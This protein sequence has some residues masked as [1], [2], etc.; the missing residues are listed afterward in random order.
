MI[1]GQRQPPK[2][3]GWFSP[4]TSEAISLMFIVPVTGKISRRNLPVVTIGLILF[5]C[6]VFFIFQSNQANQYREAEGYYFTSG[7][8]GIELSRFIKY[9]NPSAGGQFDLDT[10]GR[11]D[12][13]EI[14]RCYQEM[15]EDGEFIKK[16]R[17]EEIITPLDPDYPKWKQLRAE[18]EHLQ[19][20]IVSVKYGFIPAE[21]RPITFFTYMFLHGGFEHLLGNM[22]F[23]WLV[24]CMIEMGSSR[25][26]CGATYILTGLGAVWLF[27]LLNPQNGIQLVGASGSIAGLMG[28]FCV[29]YGRKKVK[30]FYS[31]GI[32]FNYFKA[33]AIIILPIWIAKE[34][35]FLYADDISNIAYEAHL[36]GLLSGASLGLL[37][38]ILFR[39]VENNFLAT[40]EAVDEISPLIEKALEHVSQLDMDA[41]SRLLEQALA[42]DPGHIAAMTH[43]FNIYKNSPQ[44]PRFHE[45]A[46]QLL[47]RLSS[48][49]ALHR[50]AGKI[51]VEYTKR[52]HRPCLS[53]DLY[54]RMIS[55]LSGLGHPEKA[56]RIMAMILKQR[57]ELPGIPAALL[58]LAEGYRRSGMVEKH[59]KCLM[60][61]GRRYPGSTEN[62]I[63]R[64]NLQRPN[65]APGTPA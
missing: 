64:K 2:H 47:V 32:Y 26:F 22:V 9:R 46:H 59:Q 4:E 49:G 41:G 34:I 35:F 56:G 51:F 14:I 58:K 39:K 18:Y 27:W 1:E 60:L 31:L 11:M 48:D 43:L 61:L 24:A 13:E 25:V 15:R 40:G 29:L 17:S 7:L 16:L 23:L 63:A 33:P 53:A 12:E 19:S 8:A 57:P 42:K 45:I 55:V 62:Q 30:F 28:A 21:A 5:N 65:E 36:G 52:T 20:K 54:L 50:T 6:L 44:D 3:P 37:G 38:L 10:L